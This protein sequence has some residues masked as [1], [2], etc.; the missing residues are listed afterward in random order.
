MRR[1]ISQV[2]AGTLVVFS[3]LLSASV[4][5]AY[6]PGQ[7]G[8]L[9]GNTSTCS[10]SSGCS[11]TLSGSGFQPGETVGLTFNS[12]P[13]SLGTTTANSSGGF[14]FSV[15]IPAGEPAG[16]H[17]IVATGESSGTTASFAITLTAATTAAPSPS[18]GLAFTGADISALVGVGAVVIALGGLL[19]LAS[20]RR[21]GRQAPV[22]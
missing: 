1:Y 8:T 10:A 6:G 14:T 3:L 19:V 11:L 5:F 18:G 7:T 13:V 12:T 22:S 9:T 17:T 20:R 15:T 16:N 4:A 21:R 2:V